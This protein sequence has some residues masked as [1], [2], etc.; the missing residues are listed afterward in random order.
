MKATLK[1]LLATCLLIPGL[2]AVAQLTVAQWTFETNPPADLTDSSSIT[3]IAADF[4]TGTAS[5]FHAG[6]ATDWTTPAGNGSTNSL[7]ANTWAPG[8]YFQLQ[9]STL[10]RSGISV[11]FDITKSSTGPSTFAL[12]YSTDGTLFTSFGSS[13]L[14]LSNSAATDNSGTGQVTS[15]WS[16]SG[17]V[18]PAFNVSFSLSSVSALNN[19]PSVF[20]RITDVDAVAGAATGTARIDNFTVNAVPEPATFVLLATGGFLTWLG[21][22]RRLF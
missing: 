10:G 3:G 7:S 13:F 9:T 22:R 1:N 15:P 8:D 4:G 11:S 12:S 21:R 19:A 14:V 20:F 2:P 5:G 17:A 6:S 16:S 18:Q